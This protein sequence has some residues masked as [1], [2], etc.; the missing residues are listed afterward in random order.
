ML[1][2][3][4]SMIMEGTFDLIPAHSGITDEMLEHFSQRVLQTVYKGEAATPY[5]LVKGPDRHI[6]VVST[7][8]GIR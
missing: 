3:A 5:S 1:V 2:F 8:S 6:A 7:N 4:F